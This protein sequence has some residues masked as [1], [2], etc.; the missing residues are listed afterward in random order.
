MSYPQKEYIPPTN[1]HVWVRHLNEL[2]SSEVGLEGNNRSTA[3][4]RDLLTDQLYTCEYDSLAISA[5]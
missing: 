4:N 1:P 5:K 2:Q 3:A